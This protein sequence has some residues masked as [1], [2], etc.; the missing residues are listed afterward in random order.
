MNITKSQKEA[1]KKY[2]KLMKKMNIKHTEFKENI[3]LDFIQSFNI[4]VSPI[5]YINT[6]LAINLLTFA[7]DSPQFGDLLLSEVDKNIDK[8]NENT[9][10]CDMNR[11]K[12]K[13]QQVR[14]NIK[15]AEKKLQA[16]YIDDFITVKKKEFIAEVLDKLNQ[17]IIQNKFKHLFKDETHDIFIN[18]K[19][20]INLLAYEIVEEIY[21]YATKDE[22]KTLL[23]LNKHTWKTIYL[24]ILTRYLEHLSDIEIISDLNKINDNVICKKNNIII[25]SE[26]EEL[27][28]EFDF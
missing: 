15:D 27:L 5:T 24:P 22:I 21:N 25:T 4:L 18:N 7:P 8:V 13:Y 2:T 3:L 10:R 1:N 12:Y 19:S 11:I 20:S 28:K 9:C 16:K 23:I 14:Y 6:Y 17:Q 26:L